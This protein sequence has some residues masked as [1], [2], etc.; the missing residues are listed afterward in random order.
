[1]KYIVLK[2]DK[3]VTETNDFKSALLSY[4]NL[5]NDLKNLDIPT[6]YCTYSVELRLVQE[7]KF[8]RTTFMMDDIE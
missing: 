3:V 7:N 5:M 1:M 8:L 4:T 6:D 2:N